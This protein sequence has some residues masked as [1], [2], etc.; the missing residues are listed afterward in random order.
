MNMKGKEK[1]QV[2]TQAAYC[3]LHSGAL[4]WLVVCF[5][6]C[7]FVLLLCVRSVFFVLLFYM[8]FLLFS[9]FVVL[10]VFWGFVCFVGLICVPVLFSSL[11]VFLFRMQ[12][13]KEH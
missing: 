4:F 10:F 5:A 3:D 8:L 6:M 2:N 11:S 7:G 1:Q 12:N 9:L 13:L